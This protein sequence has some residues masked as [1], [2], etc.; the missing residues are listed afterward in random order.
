MTPITRTDSP[1]PLYMDSSI[2]SQ[3]STTYKNQDSQL[4]R[5]HRR[6]MNRFTPTKVWSLKV[7]QST[8]NGNKDPLTT[9]TQGRNNNSN[10]SNQMSD[11]LTNNNHKEWVHRK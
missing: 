1:L 6:H 2:R 3:S 11:T 5:V 7:I 4:T 8:V 10:S 9:I